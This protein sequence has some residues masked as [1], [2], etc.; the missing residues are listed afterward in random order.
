MFKL[1]LIWHSIIFPLHGVS[2]EYSNLSMKNK[3][4]KLLKKL[5]LT[6]V[7]IC[8]NDFVLKLLNHNT[9]CVF[10]VMH[11]NIMYTTCV[12]IIVLYNILLCYV[13]H[14]Y[15]IYIIFFFRRHTFGV[16][17]RMDKKIGRFLL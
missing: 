1:V 11:F 6:F 14:T 17:C 8:L 2:Q 15:I 13:Y 3:I 5:N 10:S 7:W 16:W 4:K 9:C 12:L